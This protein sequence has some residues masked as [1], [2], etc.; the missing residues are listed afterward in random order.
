M[1][2]LL[3]SWSKTPVP[4]VRM[5]FLFNE[6]LVFSGIKFAK[7]SLK[8]LEQREDNFELVKV[9]WEG[10][11]EG[12]QREGEGREE[13]EREGRED[14]G[15]GRKQRSNLIFFVLQADIKSIDPTV[16]QMNLV[17]LAEGTSP[18]ISPS[19]SFLFLV[20]LFSEFS[21]VCRSWFDVFYG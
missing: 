10:R 18:R 12:K 19:L 13:E 8:A 3:F 5:F 2:L 4:S 1:F 21:S 16:K 17:S 20:P 9:I 11:R 7:R 15:G 6:L 14:G